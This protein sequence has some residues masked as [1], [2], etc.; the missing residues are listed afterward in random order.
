VVKNDGT[1]DAC[2]HPKTVVQGGAYI[3][4]APGAAQAYGAAGAYPGAAGHAVSGAP[5][6]GGAGPAA[7]GVY[8]PQLAAS[9]AAPVRGRDTAVMPVGIASDPIPPADHNRPHV[10]RHMLHLDMIG[11]GRAQQAELHRGEKHASIPYGPQGQATV[12]ELPAKV[13]YGK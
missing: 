1:C 13:V 11:R 7:I 2:G 12:T 4:Q 3:Q 9:A 8:P 10:V 5:N 6:Y